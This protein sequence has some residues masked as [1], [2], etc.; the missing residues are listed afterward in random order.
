[1]KDFPSKPDGPMGPWYKKINACISEAR[2]CVT[3]SELVGQI[4]KPSLIEVDNKGVNPGEF[5]KSIDAGNFSFESDIL[6]KY[7]DPYRRHIWYEFR[8][9]AINEDKPIVPFRSLDN[10]EVGTHLS[11]R[12]GADEIES[13]ESKLG[14]SFPREY[15]EFMIRY[16]EGFL[17]GFIRVYPPERIL[18]G[19]NGVA[20]WRERVD[21]FWCW[22]EGSDVLSKNRALEC[23]IVADTYGGDEI[24]YHPSS[25]DTLYA[26]P[27]HQ[28]NIHIISR[29]GLIEAIDWI[30]SSGE[31]S[32]PIHDR[33]FE[34]N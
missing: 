22:D 31:L 6:A 7:R 9:E 19:S 24:I 20:E 17:A 15:R 16:G 11:K 4:G 32:S 26:L 2:K 25:P 29:N 30:V 5:I 27:R 1:V 18:S 21:E 34:A 12:I 3:I 10:I 14:V 8:F 13:A 33:L 28:S 23:V